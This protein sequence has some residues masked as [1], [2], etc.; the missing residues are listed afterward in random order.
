MA[1]RI[2]NTKR[3]EVINAIEAGQ[4]STKEIVKLIGVSDTTVDRIRK[5]LRREGTIKN[6]TTSITKVYT[7]KICGAECRNK[8]SYGG[9]MFAHKRKADAPKQN[10]PQFPSEITAEQVAAILLKKVAH[11]ISND[12]LQ[13]QQIR[14]AMS[15]ISKLEQKL[16]VVTQERDRVLK[17]HN[18]LVLENRRHQV[19]LPEVGELM[20]IAKVR[21]EKE[22]ANV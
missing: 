1:K 7:C 5:S 8:Y 9:H 4:L 17:T 16:A 14:D 11:A 12:D 20:R 21:P 6:T 15:R 22:T 2:P 3:I 18:D 19:E 10:S 13:S